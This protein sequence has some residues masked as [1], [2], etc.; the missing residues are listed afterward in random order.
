MSESWTHMLA[1]ADVRAMLALARDMMPLPTWYAQIAADARLLA[2][3]QRQTQIRIARSLITV[4]D[5]EIQSG[6]FLDDLAS[7]DAVTARDLIYGRYL[8]SRSLA[9]SIAKDV[10]APAAAAGESIV[11]RL[12]LD[13]FVEQKLVACSP[14][15][16]KRSMSSAVAEFARAGIIRTAANEPLIVTGHVPSQRA[17][18]HL[19]RDELRERDE[20]TDAWLAT[21]SRAATLFALSPGT[22]QHLIEQLVRSGSLT[23]SYYSG[24]PR[25]LA[26]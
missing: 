6:G 26:A 5:G 10:F 14:Q 20:A 19:I 3:D 21:Q 13:R 9:R 23:R 1:F 22:M 4:R 24:Q 11:S 25:I 8:A 7:A 2:G 18:F 15:T 16:R 12:T 17:L